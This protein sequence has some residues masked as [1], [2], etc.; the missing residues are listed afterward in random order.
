MALE[1]LRG[2]I[3]ASVM[4]REQSKFI[5]IVDQIQEQIM[6]GS[7][8]IETVQSNIQR[9]RGTTRRHLRKQPMDMC[10]ILNAIDGLEEDVVEFFNH[11]FN[12][13]GG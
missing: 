6:S 10:K 2:A 7:V 4:P 9:S 8:E 12:K 3:R 11:L 13:Q 5:A 1:R